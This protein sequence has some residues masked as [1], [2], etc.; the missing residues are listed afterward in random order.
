MDII[1]ELK[2]EDL[3]MKRLCDFIEI[4]GNEGLNSTNAL[5]DLLTI[6][7]IFLINKTKYTSMYLTDYD[8]IYCNLDK[9]KN[10]LKYN[11]MIK[12]DKS[13]SYK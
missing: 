6:Y 1:E 9:I 5:F 13:K 8:C 4:V 7:N 2:R 10:I 12:E 3:M 11:E